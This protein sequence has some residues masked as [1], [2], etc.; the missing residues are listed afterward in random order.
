MNDGSNCDDIQSI[1][2]YDGHVIRD[3][4]GTATLPD[5]HLEIADSDEI[6]SPIGH[7]SEF[8]GRS[9]KSARNL[10]EV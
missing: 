5:S 4:V 2:T 1:V 3:N 6:S 9:A 10:F 8:V 7:T